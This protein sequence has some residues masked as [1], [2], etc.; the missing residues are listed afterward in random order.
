MGDRVSK[1]QSGVH[2]ES[3]ED[4]AGVQADVVSSHTYRAVPESVA[5]VRAMVA[6]FAT[7][8]GAPPAT[9]EAVKL[10]VSEAAT[11]VVIHAYRDSAAPGLIHVE[12]ALAAG[13]LRVSITDTGPGLR[14]RQDSPGLGV[15]LAIIAELADE[16][17]L[18]Q[19]STGLRILMRFAL[20]A[21]PTQF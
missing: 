2:D 21:N 18:L 11:N 10:A 13:K 8:V 14:P 3:G 1:S 17:E 7:Q 9:V 15:G 6:D 4:T 19:G 16:I 20:P 5:V 12:A